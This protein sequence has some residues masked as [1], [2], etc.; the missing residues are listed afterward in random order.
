M[1]NCISAYVR[2]P[3]TFQFAPSSCTSWIQP[4]LASGRVK[5]IHSVICGIA[6]SE[7]NKKHF[8]KQGRSAAI[9][10]GYKNSGPLAY[11]LHI[12]I[13]LC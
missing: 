3:P 11:I 6:K 10:S 12:F 2:K 1:C 13:M 5:I 4:V 9:M 8:R 7:N